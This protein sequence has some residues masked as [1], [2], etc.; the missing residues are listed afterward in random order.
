MYASSKAQEQAHTS[1]S[2]TSYIKMSIRIGSVPLNTVVVRR[3][4]FPLL[5]AYLRL[6]I[7]E[8]LPESGNTSV[9]A[10]DG[11]IA[12]IGNWRIVTY[13]NTSSARRLGTPFVV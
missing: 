2:Q 11:A 10:Y 8:E 3:E 13:F 1:S 4:F 6:Q 12:W 5:R 9:P 7:Y